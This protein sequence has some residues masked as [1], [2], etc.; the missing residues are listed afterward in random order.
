MM[1][2]P[3]D[4]S[5]G[6]MGIYEPGTAMVVLDRLLE[7]KMGLIAT[8]TSRIFLVPGLFSLHRKINMA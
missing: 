1:G 3:W 2:P 4:D 6:S 8:L 7:E 5:V